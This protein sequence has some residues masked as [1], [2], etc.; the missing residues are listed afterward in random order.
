MNIIF[1]TIIFIIGIIIGRY[2][3][4]EASDIPKKLDLK[5]KQYS[6]KKNQ[7]MVS[8]L[9]YMFI[10]G[11]SSVILANTLKINVDEFDMTNMIIY[12]F[13]MLYMSTLVIIGG[14]DKN[15]SKI[16]KKILAFG[17]VSSIVYM[18][19]IFIVDSS[20][21][22]I[23]II[24]LAIY[25]VL[26]IIDSFLL[27][28]FAKDSYIV[29]LLMLISI[30]LVYSNLRILIYTLAMSVIAILMYYVI[31]ES[32]KKKNGN[33]KIKLNEIPVGFFIATSNIIVLFMIRIFQNYLV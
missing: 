4:L 12:V 20:S 8:K 11:V 9:T 33:K 10:G 26:L 32:Q 25:M 28:K 6:N 15:Y 30:I 7:E 23:N 14:I 27:R 24:Y 16:D 21:A 2:W 5:K 19:Y 3:E 29:N 31:L 13:A 1:Y 22:K 17:V 18:I